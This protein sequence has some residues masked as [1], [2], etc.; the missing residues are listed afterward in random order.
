M[1]TVEKWQPIYL[2]RGWDEDWRLIGQWSKKP[3]MDQLVEG[4]ALTVDYPGGHRTAWNVRG[5][6]LISPWELVEYLLV[7]ANPYFPDDPIASDD[8][9]LLDPALWID[10][11]IPSELDESH[12]QVIE[13]T[14][15]SLIAKTGAEALITPEGGGFL[16]AFSMSDDEIREQTADTVHRIMS[17]PNP[18]TGTDGY[19]EAIRR[20]LNGP[21]PPMRA[22]ET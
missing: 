1:S 12:W 5:G 8:S 9:S 20:M 18:F 15:E 17:V 22:A 11:H 13:E 6:E 2:W 4:G 14:V 21:V 10:G 16:G 7:P 19:D 3:R